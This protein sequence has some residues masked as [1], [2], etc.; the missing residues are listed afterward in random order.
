MLDKINSLFKRENI[1]VEL[2]DWY[3][4][5]K[6]P[7]VCNNAVVAKLQKDGIEVETISVVKNVTSNQISTLLMMV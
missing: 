6:E 7:E 4:W 1:F 2:E 3:K 5:Y